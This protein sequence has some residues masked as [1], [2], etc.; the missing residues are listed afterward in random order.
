MIRFDQAHLQALDAQRQSGSGGAKLRRWLDLLD[1]QLGEQVLDLGCGS[2]PFSRLA[3]PLVAPR[4]RVVGIDVAADAVEL[5]RSLSPDADTQRLTF[6][7]A[8]GAALPFDDGSFDAAACISML[9]F[10]DDPA[11]V[12]V[13]LHRVLRPGGRVVVVSSDQDTRVYNCRDRDLGRRIMCAIADRAKDPWIARRLASLLH[14]TGFRQRQ[15]LVVTEVEHRFQPDAAGYILAHGF[16]DH[17]VGRAGISEKDYARW[18]A[19]LEA[20]EREGSS[21]YSVTTYA[22]LAER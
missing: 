22:Y 19:D 5:A 17:L 15:E 21:F 6:E 16:R 11:A 1:P 2:G 18:L 12:L 20:C 13:E 4:G 3:A 10:C 8:D 7:V 9:D 14:A